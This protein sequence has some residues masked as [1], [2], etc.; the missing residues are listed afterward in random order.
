MAEGREARC[1][2]QCLLADLPC[3]IL[4]G[5]LHVDLTSAGL[6]W[7]PKKDVKESQVVE[8]ARRSLV[9]DVDGDAQAS[10]CLLQARCSQ[11]V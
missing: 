7:L 11:G 1:V 10:V 3:R 5:G 6:K 4:H 9:L 8:K 2:L